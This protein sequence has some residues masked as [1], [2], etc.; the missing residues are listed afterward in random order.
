LLSIGLETDSWALVPRSTPAPGSL[1][2]KAFF[3]P[4]LTLEVSHVEAPQLSS[5]LAS[6]QLELSR[7][8]QSAGTGSPLYFDARSGNPSQILA[9]VPVIPGSGVGNRVSLTSLSATLGREVPQV[10]AALVSELVRRF[11]V[12]HHVALGVEIEQLGDAVASEPTAGLWHVRFPQTVAGIPVRYAGLSATLNSGNLVLIGSDVW[13]RVSTP[14]L[15]TI[16]AEQALD[17]GFAFV[18]GRSTLD[19]I[20]QQPRLE[21]I[22]YASSAAPLGS[23]Y[24]HYLAWSFVFRRLNEIESWELLVDA[25]TGIVL[26]MTD[27]NHYDPSHATGGAYPL[28]NTEICPNNATCGVMQLGEPLPHVD[29][30]LPAPNNFANAAGVFEYTS[31]TATTALAGRFVRMTDTCGPI[32]FSSANGELAL[33]GVNGQH[34]CVSSG[35]SAG[36]TPASRS[37]YYELNKLIEMAKG[38][39][40]N[41]PWLNTRITSNMNIIDTCNAFYSRT[42]GTINFFRSGGGCRNTGEIAAIFDHEWG[43]ALDDNDSIGEMSNSAEAYADI[44][45][46]YRLR[47]SCVG[48]GF[49]WTTNKGCGQTADGTGFNQNES[50]TGSYCDTNCS[51]VRD[52]DWTQ[53]ASNQPATAL[54]FVCTHCSSGPGPCGRQ[55]HCAAA[56]SRQAAW[57]LAA[58]DLQAPPHNLSREDAFNLG[59]KLFFQGSGNIGAWNA[60]ACGSSSD[61]C[62]STNGYMQWLAADDDDGNVSNGT[63]HMT[64][65]HAA[66]ARHGIACNTPT[67]VDSGCAGVPTS[68]PAVTV[69]NAENNSIGLSWTPVAGASSYRVLR[70]EG[71]AGCDFGKAVVAET[72]STVFTDLEVANGRTYYYVVQ[73]VGNSPACMGPSS[74]CVSAIPEPCSGSLTLD[75]GSYHCSDQ[76]TIR[77]SDNDLVG[78]GTLT[79]SMRSSVETVPEV[80]TLTESPAASGRFVG[81]IATSSRLPAPNGVVEVA[82]G[83][84]VTAEYLDSVSC[85]QN[86]VTK[87]R[88]AA[89]DCTGQACDGSLTIDRTLYT[90]ADQLQISLVDSDLIGLGTQT[91]RVS[92]TVEATPESL[93][94]TESPPGSGTFTGMIPTTPA[95]PSTDGRIST[96][97]DST[98]TVSYTDRSAC[99]ILDLV[100][101]R[102][103]TTDCRAPAISSVRTQK[104][105]GSTAEVLWNTD[106]PSTSFVTYG[107]STPPTNSTPTDVNRVTSHLVKLT[108]LPECTK[109]YFSVGS[110]DSLGQRSVANNSG[111][112]YTFDVGVDVPAN[113]L[114]PDTPKAIPESSSFNTLVNIPLPDDTRMVVDVDLRVDIL[115][116]FVGSVRLY[117][118]HPDGT[119]ITL[120]DRRGGNAA[121]FT[122]TIFD[123]EAATAISQGSA[124]WTGRYR[125]D[126]PLNRLDGKSAQGTWRLEVHDDLPGHSGT[127]REVELMLTVAQ[128]CAPHAEAQQAL[129]LSDSCP[130]GGVGSANGFWDDGEN[131]KFKLTLHNDGQE[132]LTGISAL[133]SPLTAGVAMID[134]FATF[135]D[136][137]RNASAESFAPHYEAQIQP[138]ML[139]GTAINFEVQIRTDQ[140]TYLDTITV[141]RTGRDVPAGSTTVFFESFGT[142]IPGTWEIESRGTGSGPVATWTDQ[143]PGN[144]PA[145]SPIV[146]PFAIIDSEVAGAGVEQDER[147]ISPIIDLSGA[148]NARIEFDSFFNHTPGAFERGD[149]DV[150]SSLTGNDWVNVFRYQ[151]T[152]ANPDHRV[153]DI[154]AQAAGASDVQIQFRYHDASF[155]RWWMV[156][157]VKVLYDYPASCES[158]ACPLTG[159][160][161][162]ALRLDWDNSSLLSWSSAPGATSY[163]VYRGLASDLPKLR[164]TE[165]DSCTRANTTTTSLSGVTE[166]PAAGSFTWWLVRGVN[167]SGKGS[168]GNGSGSPRV[169]ESS[170]VC[171]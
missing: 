49:F 11:V 158:I 164:T 84:S 162:E 94:L 153:I 72:P 151:A 8:I 50:Q 91:V 145:N 156:D 92:S 88:S 52:A 47:A 7:L 140:G 109:Q 129:R 65:I 53:H 161:G 76:I 42:D 114:S 154:T 74:S 147:L 121:N 112:Y 85:G 66:F 19:T 26:S 73:P 107:T 5:A 89:I 30:G 21:L 78:A 13:S 131:V 12:Q 10:D 70:T 105:T 81:T 128:P 90:C 58:R 98:V 97:H 148:S 127:V 106:E 35:G 139:C 32:N 150:M 3:R 54:G 55:V 14:L 80:V 87:Q 171:P 48:Y 157:N 9:A 110:D 132:P 142:G 122:N 103:A 71:Y 51:G 117:L 136:L 125:P 79:V 64:A 39:L 77:V 60:C 46:I 41:N 144:R 59:A 67:P 119:L 61:G 2:A 104:V 166:R 17:A 22:P 170:G 149:V 37:G 118:R 169:Q 29:T 159:V 28:T 25:H 15:P 163:E 96:Q 63:P 83:G 143:N 135:P 124:P 36:N 152:S 44:A 160:P 43:H 75:R 141:G 130:A 82:T 62:G 40:P 101:Q 24:R 113:T 69:Q 57:D 33:G 111:T 133:L 102:T 138:G 27:Q 31:G 45:S 16:S 165:V 167:S 168:I 34:D 4:E 99:G 23:G 134:D 68:A 137:A 100:D 1:A 116:T 108:G 93:V 120:V 126:T 123:D 86:N 38:W 115:H 20:W 18:G 155:N 56:P 6:R 146:H 95:T